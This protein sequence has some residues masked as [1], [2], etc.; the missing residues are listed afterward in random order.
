MVLRSLAALLLIGCAG[1]PTTAPQ[2]GTPLALAVVIDGAALGSPEAR[3]RVADELAERVRCS[4]H[5]IQRIG[6]N[7][8]DGA[9]AHEARLHQLRRRV[10]DAQWVALIELQATYRNPSAGRFR[11]EVTAAMTVASADASGPKWRNQWTIPVLLTRANQGAEEALAGALDEISARFE[12]SVRRLIQGRK[13][14]HSPRLFYFAMV[15]RFLDGD[16]S[17]NGV[18]MA[19]VTVAGD[20]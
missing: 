6:A 12:Q 5:T 3:L 8:F 14:S 17:N 16:G 10:D 19:A 11:W 15:D 4:G 18:M 2:T 13:A 7:A 20:Q 9:R 1:A